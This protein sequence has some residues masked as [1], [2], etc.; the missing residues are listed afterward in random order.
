MKATWEKLENNQGVLTVEVEEGKVDKAIDQAFT[1]V[2]KQVNLPGFRKGRVPRKIFEARFGVESLYQDALDI[3]LP[4]AY[5]EAVNQ[6]GIDPVDRPE[7]DVE[8]IEKGQPLVFKATVTVKPEVKLGEYKGLTVEPKDFSV[9]DESIQEELKTM[10]DRNAELVVEEDG[11]IENGDFAIIDFEG[12]VNGETFEGGQAENYQLEIGSGTFIPGFEEQ[13]LGK[14]KGEEL[15]VNVTFPEEYH[16]AELAGKPAVFKVKINEIKRKNL[17]ELDDEFAKDV[18]EFDTLDELKADIKAK[19]EEKAKTDA[20]NY[21]KEALIEQATAN[22]TIDIPE[23][24]V[25]HEVNHMVDDFS[26]RLQYQGMNLDLYYQFTGL[27]EEKLREQFQADAEKRVRTTLTLE[28]IGKDAGIEV[29]DEEVN[30]ELSQLAEQYNR[31]VEELR[32]IFEAQGNLETLQNDI[33]I[34][35]TIDLL[36]ENSK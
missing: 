10:Q 34:R 2:V 3:L 33:R 9:T 1:K 27:D 19:L 8:N 6:T 21:K 20:E 18:S 29:T 5:S 12:S 31:P 35:K 28:A 22:A 13:L 15:E 23:V 11:A 26:Q 30:E 32:R 14:K 17:P 24:M 36:V 7:V 16:A 25:E 4:E